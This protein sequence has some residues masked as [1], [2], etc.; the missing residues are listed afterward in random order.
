MGGF[1]LG[2]DPGVIPPLSTVAPT[3]AARVSPSF[4]VSY[5][6]RYPRAATNPHGRQ[7]APLRRAA[8]VPV[9]PDRVPVLSLPRGQ[10]AH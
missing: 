7:S 1:H 9:A 8:P 4:P 5:P 3:G 6:V 10:P 2:I